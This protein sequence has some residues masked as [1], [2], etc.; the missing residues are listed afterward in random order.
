MKAFLESLKTFSM[1]IKEEEWMSN[2]VKINNCDLAIKEYK[3]ERVITFKEM[4]AVHGRK[5][6]SAK[7]NFNNNKDKF[8][9]NEDYFRITMKEYREIF[10]PNEK[11]GRGNPT[12]EVILLTEMGYLML[13]RT[14]SDALA[15]QI[16]RALVLNYFRTKQIIQEVQQVQPQET[17]IIMPQNEFDVMRKMIDYLEEQRRQSERTE[18]ALKLVEERV[19]QITEQLEERPEVIMIPDSTGPTYLKASDIAHQLKLYSVNGLPHNRIIGAIARKLGFKINIR[20]FYQD[21]Y[22][23][24]AKEGDDEYST[25]QV[26]YTQEGADKIIDWFNKNKEDIYYESYYKKKSKYGDV[27]DVREA[28]Y[29]V[30]GVRWAIAL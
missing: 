13:V 1:L 11:P 20:N 14:F 4:D 24:I 29:K 9:E 26:Y 6:G 12:F 3:D 23:M 19:N 25:W 18:Q 5:P 10:T 17:E 2:I 16:Q 8:I 30:G 7:R 22:I 28:G 15:W 21:D 27:G